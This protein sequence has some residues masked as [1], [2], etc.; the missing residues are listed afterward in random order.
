MAFDPEYLEKDFY[1]TLGVSKDASPEEVKRAYRKLAQQYHP[2]RNRGN[3][4]AEERFKEIG[5][6]YAVL[7][8]PKKRKEYDEA[9]RLAQSGAFAGA[10]G[11]FPYAGG[12]P[13]GPYI[14]VEDL[15]DLDAGGLGGLFET[16]F[17]GTRPGRAA[18][19]RRGADVEA[20]VLLEFEDAVRGATVPVHLR[21]PTVCRACRGSGAKPG[22]LPRP[23]PTC[24]GRGTITRDQGLFGF[25][26][27]CPTCGGRGSVVDTPCPTCRG[28]GEEVRTRTVPVR[29]PAG[30]NDN[31]VLRVR[32][33]GEPGQ[34]GGP[35]GDLL[36]RVRVKPHRLFGRKGRDLTLTVPVT[37]PEAALGTELKVPTLDGQVPIRI[38]P[39]TPSG[40]TFR[41]RG[42]GVPASGRNPAG[43]LLVTI[44]VAV[45]KKLSR[46]ERE[47][48]RE[49]AAAG[50]A[51]PREHLGEE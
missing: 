4:E 43:D 37:F 7:S 5:R 48:L 46:R 31:A 1:A 12:F 33:Q 42:R 23:C 18:G 10:R 45:P 11:G 51:P 50:G 35:P 29:I 8:D 30:V 47:L 9:R 39:G 34:A 2:D 25:S 49:L 16:L 38:P 44:Q 36:L 20:E 13:R 24:G 3:K 6:A 17:G 27:P 21:G 28:S 22:T 26:S 19:P 40:K 32:G 14:R 15:G 41:V